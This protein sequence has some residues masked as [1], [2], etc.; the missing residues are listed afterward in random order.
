ME[1]TAFLH[2]D[3]RQQF[4]EL[5][6]THRG[7]VQKVAYSSCAHPDDRADL[8]LEIAT[9]LWRAFPRYDAE[10][11]F[12]TWMYRIALNVAISHLRSR[13]IGQFGELARFERDDRQK[14]SGHYAR[15]SVPA[16]TIRPPC[17]W[18]TPPCAASPRTT[19]SGARSSGW[20]T[21]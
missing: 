3:A 18:E 19:A 9:Q 15:F 14:K 7:I 12:P 13:A 10:R 17:A 4:R 8:A 11:S 21:A 6:E 2:D 20:S 16:A 1:M 5:L